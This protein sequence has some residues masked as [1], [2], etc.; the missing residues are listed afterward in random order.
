MSSKTLKAIAPLIRFGDDF[1]NLFVIFQLGF[2]LHWLGYNLPLMKPTSL[3]TGK[4]FALF[5]IVAM[6]LSACGGNLWGSSELY[7]TSTPGPTEMATLIPSQTAEWAASSLTPT[8]TRQATVTPT[9]TYTPTQTLATRAPGETIAYTS[10]S[11]DSL[12]VIAIRFGV[13]AAEITSASPLSSAG[14][15]NPGTLLFIPNRLSGI[16]TTPPQSI[17]PDSELV[18]SPSAVGFDIQAYVDSA[19]GRLS[20]LHD[21]MTNV[22]SIS[23]AEGVERISL[24]SSI[25]PRLLLA[26]IQQYTGWVQGQS[27]PGLDE[28]YPFGYENPAYTGFYQQMRLVVQDLLSGYYG[29]QAGTLTELTFP[30]GTTLR[31]APDLNAGTVALQYFFSRHLNQDDWLKV[32]DPDTGFISL[33]K[34]MFGDPW[35]RANELGPLFPPNL[36]QPDFTLP[37]EVGALWAFTS[38]PHP[39]W[40]QESALAALD[41]APAMAESGCGESNAWVVAIAPGQI[42]RSETGFVVLDMDGDGF[43]QTGWVVLYQHIATKGRIPAGTWVN[44]GDHI[45]HPSCEGGLA[46]G[47]H[48]HITRKYNGEWV[49]AGGPLPFV[50]S[51]WTVHAGAEPRQGTMTKGDQ[52][53]IASSVGSRESQIIR[54][55]GE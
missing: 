10:Q 3:L 5:L 43:E 37:F 38:G 12:A 27:L 21:Y 8:G 24:G 14:F 40:E 15:I 34:G 32:I 19:D 33:Y 44:A 48:V 30:D 9:P 17:I 54:Q 28:T 42:V 47:T 26:L 53:I 52:V 2:P 16:P 25:S 46:T 29:W 36:N 39:A 51:G 13:D 41:F 49:A 31:I 1:F 35:E 7:Q 20:T 45:G 4:F 6:S 23:G 11:G 18:D 22:G 50:L 55:P